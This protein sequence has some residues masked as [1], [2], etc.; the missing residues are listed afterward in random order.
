MIIRSLYEV[1]DKLNAINIP[2][3]LSGSVAMGFYTVNRTTY[4]IDLIVQLQL[5]DADNLEKVFENY[6]FYKPT[7][8]EEIRR[9][10]MFNVISNETGFKIDFILVKDDA[11]SRLAFERRVLLADFG[12][13]LYVVSLED[14][15]LAKLKWI[16]QIFSERQCI[17]ISNLIIGQKP[18]MEYVRYWIEKLNLKTFKLFDHE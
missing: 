17:D 14:L 18:D 1:V 6:Y 10:G 11:Y 16:Q 4:D 8:I 13:P 15:I 2:Y 3:M 9:N 7:V 12:R 5:S